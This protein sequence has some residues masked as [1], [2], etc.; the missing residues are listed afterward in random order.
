MK[1]WD[2]QSDSTKNRPVQIFNCG[3]QMSDKTISFNIP[4]TILL[5]GKYLTLQYSEVFL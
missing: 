4:L 2:S 3:C 1:A 5:D